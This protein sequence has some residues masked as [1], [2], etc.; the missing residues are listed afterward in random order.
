[1]PITA[2]DLEI[3]TILTLHNRTYYRHEQFLHDIYKSNRTYRNE[4]FLHYEMVY[5]VKHTIAQFKLLVCMW[6]KTFTVVVN[7]KNQTKTR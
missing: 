4:Q 5:I 7:K 6:K 2:S 3:N 1:M